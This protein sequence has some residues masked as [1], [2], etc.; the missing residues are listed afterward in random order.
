MK[1]A[2]VAIL[3]RI[4]LDGILTENHIL[5]IINAALVLMVI[6][7]SLVPE[8]K[9]CLHDSRDGMKEPIEQVLVEAATML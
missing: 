6:D 9:D 1:R 4:V 8:R 7:S 5:I 3:L 2:A